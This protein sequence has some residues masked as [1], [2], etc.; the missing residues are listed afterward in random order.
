M[1]LIL[2]SDLHLVGKSPAER[3]DDLTVT[4]WDKMK[5]IFDY[6]Q[7]HKIKYILQAGDFFDVPRHWDLFG[8]TFEFLKQYR[9][10]EVLSVLGQ[11]DQYMR[12]TDVTTNRSV[13]KWLNLIQTPMEN[14]NG[15]LTDAG[16]NIYGISF[17]DDQNIDSAIDEVEAYIKKYP[18]SN[19]KSYRKI[20][21]IHAPIGNKPLF[22][23]H[24]Y[25][26]AG[27]LLR[28][29]P[30]FDVIL[31]GD[32]H[33]EFHVKLGDHHIVNTG[34]LLRKENNAYNQ[35]HQPCFY[36]YDTIGK[37]YKKII[38]HAPFGE[39]F[40][41]YKSE[42]TNNILD[43]FIDIIK[44]P[45]THTCNIYTTIENILQENADTMSPGVKEILTKLIS[46]RKK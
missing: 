23:G 26:H 9:G 42:K 24:E 45:N 27:K 39:I 31:C 35:F 25:T 5:F 41:Q 12:N 19:P 15:F 33:Q 46:E 40:S 38:P 8:T 28:K 22:P 30:T 17:Q 29:H 21:M 6:A 20:L 43:Q 14:S 16:I 7:E 3:L 11:H 18:Q 2:L 1:K 44:K 37:F 36:I 4:Q 13:L 34:P 32:I 10:I